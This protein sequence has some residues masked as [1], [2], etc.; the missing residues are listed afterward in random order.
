V[1]KGGKRQWERPTSSIL[2]ASEKRKREK[3]K[4]RKRKKKKKKTKKKTKKKRKKE[5]KKKRKR[6][7]PTLGRRQG[8]AASGFARGGKGEG[9]VW[10]ERGGKE[11][12]PTG[13]GRKAEKKI[14]FPCCGGRDLRMKKRYGGARNTKKGN[15]KTRGFLSEHRKGGKGGDNRGYRGHA[16]KKTNG[17]ADAVR[18][19][20][21]ERRKKKKG[22]RKLTS[23]RK[24]KMQEGKNHIRTIARRG[25]V[26]QRPILGAIRKGGKKKR[27]ALRAPLFDRGGEEGSRQH[28]K[29]EKKRVFWQP[30]RIT[31]RKGGENKLSCLRLHQ[32][33]KKEG[34]DGLRSGVPGDSKPSA[35]NEKGLLRMWGRKREKRSFHRRGK[36]SYLQHVKKMF[37][38]GG[39]KRKR[40]V[41][42]LPSQM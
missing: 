3:K 7:R 10:Y 20:G 26:V 11:H 17:L 2:A 4:K 13:L 28:R 33:K 5:I 38:K 12:M 23:L 36:R 1:K 22:F 9:F 42:F 35:E 31:R 27:A 8:N 24:K 14:D 34:G 25:R 18:T 32:E 29:R 21:K 39:G 41:G 40:K 16:R 19:L 30:L 37:I 15:E 6:T